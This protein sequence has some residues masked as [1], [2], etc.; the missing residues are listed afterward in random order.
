MCS[1][2]FVEGLGSCSGPKLG[3]LFCF[4]RPEKLG[5]KAGF[6]VTS[7]EPLPPPWASAAPLKTTLL[8][9]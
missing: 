3:S 7:G 2:R 4:E 1:F 8:A 5:R 6:A 9:L